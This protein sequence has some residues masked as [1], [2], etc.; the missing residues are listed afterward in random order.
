MGWW[1]WV[2]YQRIAPKCYVGYSHHT[3]AGPG[4]G[5]AFI[6]SRYPK[7]LSLSRRMLLWVSGMFLVFSG[8]YYSQWRTGSSRVLLA[9]CPRAQNK[10]TLA[11]SVAEVGSYPLR[12]GLSLFVYSLTSLSPPSCS[13]PLS[14]HLCLV[15]L[16]S[17]IT[18]VGL[19]LSRGCCRPKWRSLSW[20]LSL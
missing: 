19:L 2:S 18:S 13:C 1:I 9:W 16:I 15:L 5:P 4:R 10:T 20:A 11:T 12:L 3:K 8:L 6:D 17:T 7:S 14:A